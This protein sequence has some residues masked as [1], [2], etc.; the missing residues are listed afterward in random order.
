MLTP[1]FPKYIETYVLDILLYVAY[2]LR[3]MR[4]L[5]SFASNENSM[6]SSFICRSQGASSEKKITNDMRVCDIDS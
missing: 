5:Q 1:S 6:E 3:E 2:S 4:E